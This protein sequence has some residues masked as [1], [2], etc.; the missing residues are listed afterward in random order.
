MSL[1]VVQF[2]DMAG[3]SL[4]LDGQVIASVPQRATHPLN[5]GC[6]S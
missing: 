5:L 2:W 3:V 1:G 6:K 4:H